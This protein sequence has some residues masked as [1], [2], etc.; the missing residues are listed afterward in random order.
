MAE[1]NRNYISDSTCVD[2]YRQGWKMI[3]AT[4]GIL[5]G[6]TLIFLVIQAPTNWTGRYYQHGGELAR[7]MGAGAGAGAGLFATLYWVFLAGP[8][9]MSFNW[10]F[11]KAARG[12]EVRVGDMFAVFTRNYWNA[13]G[14]GVLTGL[15]IV[16]GFIFLIVPGVIFAVRLVFVPYLIIDRRMGVTEAISTSWRMTKGRG[17]TI[18][19]MGLLAIPIFIGGLL[20]LGVGV[21]VSMMWTAA[22]FAVLYHSVTRGEQPA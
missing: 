17:G 4:F 22:A 19:L 10:A 13:V 6:I 3:F 5:L 12:E 11:L 9:S 14:A 8:I 18:F 16:V 2:N 20:A 21:V 1:E 15:I 7:G